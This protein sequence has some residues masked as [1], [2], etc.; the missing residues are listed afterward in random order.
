MNGLFLT[1]CFSACKTVDTPGTQRV[2]APRSENP[3]IRSHGNPAP[4]LFTT[5]G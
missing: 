5:L 3:G 4:G 2:G 1:G